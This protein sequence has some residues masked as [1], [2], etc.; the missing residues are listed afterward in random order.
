MLAFSN[1]YSPELLAIS[2]FCCWTVP[3]TYRSCQHADYYSIETGKVGVGAP[4]A[5]H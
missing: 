5:L 1:C 3:L 4:T 2:G